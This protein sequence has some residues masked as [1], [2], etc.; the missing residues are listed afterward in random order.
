M[1]ED[2]EAFVLNNYYYC[3]IFFAEFEVNI[4][5]VFNDDYLI[6][7]NFPITITRFD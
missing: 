3:D 4:V 6:T 5:V 2:K 7:E 1:K